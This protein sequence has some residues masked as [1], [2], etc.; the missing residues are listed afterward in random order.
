MLCR[1]GLKTLSK[2]SLLSSSL[3]LVG[4]TV[5]AQQPAVSPQPVPLSPTAK[6][7]SIA[8][9]IEGKALLQQAIDLVKNGQLDQAIPLFQRASTLR[10]VDPT[11][12]FFLGLVYDQK[13]MPQLALEN[14]SLSLKR[15]NALGLDS[16][17][18]RIN[19]GNTLCK[20]NFLKEAEFDYKRAIEIDDKNDVAH[21]NFGR[22]LLFKGDNQGAFRE[23]SRASELMATDLNLPLYQALALKGMG[24]RDECK[25]QLQIFLERS[26]GTRSDPRVIN[27][28]Q[29]L[30]T[31]LK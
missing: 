3:F 10:Y 2:F 18:L 12:H 4:T 23:F 16:A 28:A 11:A 14:Y 24:N 21:I 13:G 5:H 1:F 17:Q 20:L 6:A 15:A 8:G 31:E 25:N 26:A 27:M 19:L 7:A 22:V 30:L 9:N 29:N